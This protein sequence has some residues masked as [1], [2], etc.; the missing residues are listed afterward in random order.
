MRVIQV[1]V[2]LG[3]F[4]I[5]S[6]L[7]A[8]LAPGMLG[9]GAYE[10]FVLSVVFGGCYLLATVLL[11]MR[12]IYSEHERALLW[13]ACALAWVT[14]ASGLTVMSMSEFTYPRSTA[15]FLPLFFLLPSLACSFFMAFRGYNDGARE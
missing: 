14:L 5:S 9:F 8:R 7:F 12:I 13:V 11:V 10:R 6:L 3:T 2:M 4:Y 1:I 15:L